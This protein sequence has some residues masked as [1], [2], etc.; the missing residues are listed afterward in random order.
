MNARRGHGFREVHVEIDDIGDDLQRRRDDAA[1]AREPVTMKSLPSLKRIVGVIEE[2]GRAP[3][4]TEFAS[5]P[6]RP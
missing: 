5:E 3:G 6:T 1:A 2:S 4:C